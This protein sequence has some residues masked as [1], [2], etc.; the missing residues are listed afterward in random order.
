[1]LFDGGWGV[2]NVVFV[3]DV[4]VVIEVVLVCDEVLGQVMFINGDCLVIW[5]E[6][7]CSF[8]VM[9]ELLLYFIDFFFVEVKCYWV[10][11]L[12]E[13]VGGIVMCVLCKFKCFGGWRLFVVFWL[14][15]GCVLCEIFFIIFV[16]DKV[17]CLFDWVL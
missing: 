12:F 2:C 16:N 9:V 7:I 15:L 17:K 10:E 1:M 4:C 3:D 13:F 14:L 11:Y 5:G 6:F 8:V